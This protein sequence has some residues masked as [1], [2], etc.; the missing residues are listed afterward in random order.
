MRKCLTILFFVL[1]SAGVAAS[2]TVDCPAGM[3]CISSAA[4]R[5]AL[6]A[7]DD[8]KAEKALTL[9]QNLAIDGLKEELNRIRVE[10]ARTMG[11]KTQLEQDRVRWT[12]VID[13]L[14]K[15]SRKKSIGLI[16]F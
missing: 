4:A 12:A 15:N 14:I 8:L 2:Q 11:E 9:A 5:A 10:L 6:K 13:I 1:A 7:H 16:A 3:V